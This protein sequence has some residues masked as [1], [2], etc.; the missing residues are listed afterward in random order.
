ML[1]FQRIWTRIAMKPYV[2][3]IFQRGGGTTCQPQD[4]RMGSVNLKDNGP[5]KLGIALILFA[6][7]ISLKVWVFRK[8]SFHIWHCFGSCRLNKT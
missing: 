7:T 2:F 4:P 8:L 5:F 6:P 1:N 3:V